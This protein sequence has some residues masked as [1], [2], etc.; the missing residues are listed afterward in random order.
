[1]AEPRPQSG[2]SLADAIVTASITKIGLWLRKTPREAAEI[3]LYAYELGST[4][5]LWVDTAKET[6]QAFPDPD[7]LAE[8]L[9]EQCQNHAASYQAECRYEIVWKDDQGEVVGSFQFRIIPKSAA[10]Q[11]FT[12]S[13]ENVVVQLQRHLEQ[14]MKIQAQ[15]SE[16]TLKGMQTVI[17][18]QQQ[19]ITQLATKLKEEE[20]E[21]QE[22]ADLTRAIG[23]SELEQET[24]QKLLDFLE[25]VAPM[26]LGGT[27]KQTPTQ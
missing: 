18:T 25:R 1:M 15:N 10:G 7:K 16:T 24:Q 19:T 14:V 27:P 6:T 2:D 17:E 12:G 4:P 13:M 5:T 23:E 8:F 22:I 21:K 11:R 26:L 9:R 20:T 3:R